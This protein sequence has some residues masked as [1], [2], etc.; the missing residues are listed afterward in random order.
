MRQ[1]KTKLNTLK[2]AGV[3]AL[4]LAVL[5]VAVQLYLIL[6]LYLHESQNHNI[7]HSNHN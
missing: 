2:M 1:P 5:Y 4:V 6:A 7:Q 3:A